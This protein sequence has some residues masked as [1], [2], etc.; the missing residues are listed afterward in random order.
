MTGS[1]EES[2]REAAE[3]VASVGK[4]EIDA[5]DV[6]GM[7]GLTTRRTQHSISIEGVE[8]YTW[9]AYD[10]VGIAA[11]LA[12]EATGTTRCGMCDRIIEVEIRNGDPGESPVVGW[13]PSEACSN[14]RA[15]FCPSAL[16]FCSTE[17]LEVWRLGSGA[18]QGEALDLRALAERGREE[19]AQLVELP[20]R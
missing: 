6:V 15:E 8:L 16:F 10:I 18:G 19:W 14:V 12:C 3:K 4:A 13:F 17:H 2:V 1:T 11:S 9:C 20:S 5:T 7:E